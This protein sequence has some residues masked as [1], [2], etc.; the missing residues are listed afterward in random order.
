L[1]SG[2]IFGLLVPLI[3]LV[4]E[5]TLV[6]GSLRESLAIIIIVTLVYGLI[7]GSFFALISGLL[8]GLTDTGKV[9]KALPNQ[10]IKLSRRNS[11]AVFV[12]T[13]L[14][15]GLIGAVIGGVIGGLSDALLFGLIVGLSVGLICGVFV[16]L[17][18]GLNRGGSAV[19][20]HY[21]LRVILWLK[22][23]TP[24][25][26]VSLLD[27]CA[28]LVLLKKVGG[29]YI[30]VHR[31]LLEYFADLAPQSEKVGE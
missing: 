12:V 19:V 18:V 7:F 4:G 23:Y 30:F 9:G 20:K 1:I 24:L 13:L 21:A 28:R 8:G 11:L 31:M 17:I 15:L 27:Q 25:K 6:R 3:G 29:G 10:G 22:G 14:T 2:L 26:F 16:G 5:P